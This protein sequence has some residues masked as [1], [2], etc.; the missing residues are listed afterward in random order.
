E[1]QGLLIRIRNSAVGNYDPNFLD[2]SLSRGTLFQNWISAEIYA[3]D[4][5]EDALNIDRRTLRIAHASY[6][7]LQQAIHKHLEIVIKRVREEIY[8]AGSTSRKTERADAI[9]QKILS[10]TTSELAELA[11]EAVKVIKDT[12]IKPKNNA[13]TQK[14]ILKK[15]T[16]DELYTV[17]IDV[18]KETLS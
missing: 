6:V 5:L 12:W 18:A 13:S 2:Y 3:D 10:V 1:L 9:K 11:P 14:N 8:K 7:E 16:V 17:V 15:F 4:R